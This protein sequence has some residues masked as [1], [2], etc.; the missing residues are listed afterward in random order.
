MPALLEPVLPVPAMQELAPRVPASQA[1]AT[2]ALVLRALVLLALML[3]AQAQA[4][5]LL[6][7]ALRGSLALQAPPQ[8][9]PVPLLPPHPPTE[10]SGPAPMR[11]RPWPAPTP[12]SFPRAV[13]CAC[14]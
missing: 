10:H 13:R 5:T 9:A 2:P 1:L 11:L 4:P 12:M 3:R 8:Q 6:A 7:L 14:A